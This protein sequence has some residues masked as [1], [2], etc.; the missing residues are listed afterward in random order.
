MGDYRTA[1]EAAGATVHE[2]ESFGSYQG[3]WWALVTYEGQ[4]GWINGSYGSCSGCDAF[5]AEFG[6]SDDKCPDHRYEY[7]PPSCTACDAK[8]EEYDARLAL[9]GRGYLD[10]IMSQAVAIEQA[11]RNLEWDSD[12]PEMVE[13]IK[14][15]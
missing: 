7:D 4:S 12:A 1:L 13:F 8:K 9:F 6:W 5:E 10:G 2:F 11:S 15:H 3:D 14:A